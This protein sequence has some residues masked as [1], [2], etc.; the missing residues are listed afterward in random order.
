MS[1]L[2]FVVVLKITTLWLTSNF[3]RLLRSNG[4]ELG[5]VLWRLAMIY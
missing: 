2:L 5:V 3:E 4:W 1:G